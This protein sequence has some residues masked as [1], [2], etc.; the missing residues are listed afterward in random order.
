MVNTVLIV[1]DS[2]SL[3]ALIM[4]YPMVADLEKSIFVNGDVL[5]FKMASP[6]V[7]STP[8]PGQAEHPHLGNYLII[9]T[10]IFLLI[11]VASSI[12]TW[13]NRKTNT[14]AQKHP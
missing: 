1:C 10:V 9:L 13:R 3:I 5:T 7:P 11:L 6:L 14:H 2:L 12:I 4:A 8:P